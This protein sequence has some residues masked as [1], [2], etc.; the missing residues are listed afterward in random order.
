MPM[1]LQLESFDRPGAI[2]GLVGSSDNE[3]IEDVRL[4]SYEKGYAAG[5][6]D[7]A[8][9]QSEEQTRIRDDLAQNMRDLSFTYQEAR[10]HVLSGLDPLLRGMV[11]RILPELMRNTLGASVVAQITAQAEQLANAPIKVLV[12]PQ[13]KAAIENALETNE[14]LPVS[15]VEE[16]SLGDGQVQFRFDDQEHMLDLDAV[17]TSIQ[18][19]VTQFLD[20]S[21]QE[22][23]MANG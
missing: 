11:E 10:S 2:S 4:A 18:T 8:A 12:A 15:L 1:R 21:N 22:R 19:L 14:A 6:D 13:N 7:A 20:T 9:S 17:V 3:A 23:L 16:S 5:W